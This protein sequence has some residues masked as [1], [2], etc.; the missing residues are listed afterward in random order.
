[1]V[2]FGGP[3]PVV[4]STSSL[5]TS[6]EKLRPPP[7]D[8]SESALRFQESQ[9]PTSGVALKAIKAPDI[10]C[11]R[12]EFAS[13]SNIMT[14]YLAAEYEDKQVGFDILEKVCLRKLSDAEFQ[15][16][17]EEFNR[18]NRKPDDFVEGNSYGYLLKE[19]LQE[20]SIVDFR[21]DLHGDLQSLVY[22]LESLRLEGIL[23]DDYVVR[24]EYRGRFKAIFMGDYLDR[25][26]DSR[27]VLDLLLRFKIANP[28]S[29]E[30]LR[31]N[32]EAEPWRCF[33]CCNGRL[34]LGD[35]NLCRDAGIIAFPITN[36]PLSE[37]INESFERM[38]EAYIYGVRDEDDTIEYTHL[39]HGL[40][41]PDVDIEPL[42]T[43]R[44]GRA[45][46]VLNSDRPYVLSGRIKSLIPQGIYDVF[47]EERICE[48]G[49]PLAFCPDIIFSHVFDLLR[50]YLDSDGV[51]HED[52]IRGIFGA[53]REVNIENVK[54]VVDALYVDWF[55]RLQRQKLQ[56]KERH[57]DSYS[58][59]DVLNEHQMYSEEGSFVAN[60]EDP[61]FSRAINQRHQGIE[62][63]LG[64]IRAYANVV[65]T[66]VARL[67]NF[68]RGHQHFFDIYGN[69]L[70]HTLPAAGEVR[71]YDGRRGKCGDVD[72]AYRVQ[73]AAKVANSKLF[74][75]KRERGGN[76]V[77][78]EEAG[79][80]FFC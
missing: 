66:S 1:M 49:Q 12:P 28:E 53:E 50:E 26:G 72:F 13:L 15:Q 35:Y 56:G 25:G 7:L 9:T 62:L 23:D 43:S 10:M 60:Q 48:D 6:K 36:K 16:T 24:E 46:M 65:S 18:C 19:E 5:E 68:V 74:Y 31:G 59:G 76:T 3:S 73:V 70:V 55:V 2:T 78:L 77:T 32:H 17:L 14:S 58:W 71:I 63:S 30:V 29:V 67:V 69:G 34:E 64:M 40:F 79:I 61:L 45:T 42:I 39:S 44:E 21:P 22:Y 41:E 4:G 20:G 38:P 47:K 33:P 80:P 57:P 52:A 11:A 75:M 8:F 27:E 54:L 51:N 37:S